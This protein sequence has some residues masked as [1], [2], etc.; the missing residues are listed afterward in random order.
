MHSLHQRLQNFSWTGCLSSQAENVFEGI[1]GCP[2]WADSIPL[3]QVSG[4]EGRSLYIQPLTLNPLQEYMFSV[5]A[6]VATTSDGVLQNVAS[7]T[8]LLS[9]QVWF[10]RP[11]RQRLLRSPG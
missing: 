1:L 4:N 9:S 6:T 5:R 10:L 7:V 3:D 8:V 2:Q 11:W